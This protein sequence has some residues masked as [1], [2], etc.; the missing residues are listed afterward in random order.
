VPPPGITLED[1]IPMLQEGIAEVRRM[2]SDLRPSMLDDLGILSTI[3]WFCRQ[4]Q[5]IYTD[6]RIEKEVS[7]Q[8][9]EVP[10]RLKVVIYR[11]LQEAM[12][13]IAKYSGAKL[14]YL[15]LKKGKDTIEL[16]I[17]DG[18]VGFDPESCRKGLGLASMKERTELSEG[19]FSI[20]SV[21]G[22]GTVVRA[23]WK[24]RVKPR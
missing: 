18:G 1:I 8:E 20:H 5:M 7:V 15:S 9:E 22:K 2:S 23:T 3:N 13:N 10:A 6:I 4:F 17:K 19:L 14:V 24:V 21:S 12:N 11:I 16:T